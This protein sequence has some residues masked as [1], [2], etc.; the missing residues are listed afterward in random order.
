MTAELQQQQI[1]AA[2]A[3]FWS[4]LCGSY[5]ARTVGIEDASAESLV[6]FDRAYLD[7]Y[8]YLQRYLPWNSGERVLEIGLGYGTVGKLLAERN[9]DYHGLDI[10]AG[11]VAMMIHRLELLGVS[12]PS[13]CVTQG[14]ALAIPH[15]DA[16]FDVV[17]SIGCLHHTGDLPQA[18]RE[19]HRVLRPGG[20]AMV[21]VYNR[22]SFRHLVMLP[23]MALRRGL[24]RNPRRRTEFVR[25]IYDS[26][27][28]G[29]AAPATDFSSARD[30]RRM[31]GGFANVRV[32]RENFDDILLPVAGKRIVIPHEALLTNVAR[33]AGSDLYITA[34]K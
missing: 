9:L 11:P 17:V 18:V 23:A 30:V 32:R 13:S 1:D 12:D 21:M 24:W 7:M 3:D 6:R 20:Q 16:S 10:S 25:A 22:H 26:N 19:V 28:V 4:E 27:A 15:P 8:P 34:R 29:S 2:N 14:S 33:V 31:F 5:V